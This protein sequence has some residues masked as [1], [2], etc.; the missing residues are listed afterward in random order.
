MRKAGLVWNSFNY[1]L[2]YLIVFSEQMN[3]GAVKDKEEE[4]NT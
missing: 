1:L 3:E 2:A 4:R